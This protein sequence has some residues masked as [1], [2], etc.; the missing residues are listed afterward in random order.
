[1]QCRSL[2]AVILDISRDEDVASYLLKCLKKLPKNV[3]KKKVK[4]KV[5]SKSVVIYP[6]LPNSRHRLMTALKV[7]TEK[8][9]EQSTYLRSGS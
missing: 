2:I 8:S 1:M 7:L 9:T 4:F 6:S 5:R 3:G